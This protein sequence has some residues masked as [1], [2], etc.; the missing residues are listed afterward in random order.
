MAKC[1]D[2]RLRQGLLELADTAIEKT[3]GKAGE[4]YAARGSLRLAFG[5]Q[6]EALAD[7]R[8]ALELEPNNAGNCNHMAWL[9]VT[10]PERSLWNPTRAIEYAQRALRWPL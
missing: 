1:P 9:L 7:F 2:E 4:V 3:E 5:H 10:C 8:R 6:E